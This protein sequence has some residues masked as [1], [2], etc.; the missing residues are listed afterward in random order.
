MM[1]AFKEK[2]HLFVY[3][4]QNLLCPE[5]KRIQADASEIAGNN[6]YQ[7]YLPKPENQ[8]SLFKSELRRGF[9]E[10]V[11]QVITKFARC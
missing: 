6:Q 7:I 5:K 3:L 9:M 8:N 2:M 11:G 1:P 4:K 10:N